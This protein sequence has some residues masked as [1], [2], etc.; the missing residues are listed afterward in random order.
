VDKPVMIYITLASN[1]NN[2]Y[3][4]C[5]SLQEVTKN[6]NTSAVIVVVSYCHLVNRKRY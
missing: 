6:S 3:M 1:N 2:L 4:A 5:R